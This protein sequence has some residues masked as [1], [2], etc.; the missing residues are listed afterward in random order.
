[1][2]RIH[3][4]TACAPPPDQGGATASRALLGISI[5]AAWWVGIVLFLSGVPRISQTKP[6]EFKEREVFLDCLEECCKECQA[7]EAARESVKRTKTLPVWGHVG[8]AYSA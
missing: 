7:S 6:G 3:P 1:M 8:A 4:W 5:Q 2:Y